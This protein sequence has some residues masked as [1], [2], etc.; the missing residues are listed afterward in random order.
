MRTGRRVTAERDELARHVERLCR[1]QNIRI[2]E[3]KRGGGW[4]AKRERTICVR[5]AKTQRTYIIALHEI[6]HIIGRNRS[7]RR[8][9]QEAAAWE[10]V[11]EHSAVPLAPTSYGYMLKALRSYLRRAQHSGRNMAIPA[12]G[13]RFWETYDTISDRA[14]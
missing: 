2:I 12:E 11:I 10:F 5:P 14:T 8:L 4:A 3:R 1:E 7:G 6:G 13:H 9:E